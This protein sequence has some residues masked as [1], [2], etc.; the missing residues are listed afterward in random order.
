M[1]KCLTL[2]SAEPG[3][4]RACSFIWHAWILQRL[5]RETGI[6]GIASESESDYYRAEESENLLNMNLHLYPKLI[7][8]GLHIHI[9]IQ[10]LATVTYKGTEA[11]TQFMPQLPICGQQFIQLCLAPLYMFRH[12][13]DISWEKIVREERALHTLVSIS[14][15]SPLST[16]T[17]LS[18]SFLSIAISSYSFCNFSIVF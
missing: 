6:V 5:Q 14:S 18:F 3:F 9:Y 4:N 7:S 16:S 12:L 8:D 10:L 13:H 2:A 17:S 15:A 1:G 11:H